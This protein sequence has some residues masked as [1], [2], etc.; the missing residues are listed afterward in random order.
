MK[1]FLRD[2]PA[3]NLSLNNAGDFLGGNM[4]LGGVG[5]GWG[6]GPLDSYDVTSVKRVAADRTLCQNHVSH[7]KKN[8]LLSIILVV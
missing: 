6:V 3:V 8:I 1:A 4:V 7:E 5:P 2:Q